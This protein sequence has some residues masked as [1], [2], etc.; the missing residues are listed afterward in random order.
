MRFRVFFGFRASK[1]LEI[2]K[3]KRKQILKLDRGSFY[4]TD[5]NDIVHFPMFNKSKPSEFKYSKPQ[6]QPKKSIF[7]RIKA[8]FKINEYPSVY[9]ESEDMDS[10]LE[11]D[12]IA[13][14]SGFKCL[15]D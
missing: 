5:L 4:F 9:D 15:C 3:E 10:E 14:R 2:G 6:P 11:E 1:I 13:K 8:A 7:Q 12:L